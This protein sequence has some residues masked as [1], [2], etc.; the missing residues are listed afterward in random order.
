ME[1]YIVIYARNTATLALFQFSPSNQINTTFT[2]L[3]VY[4]NTQ[5]TVSMWQTTLL[6]SSAYSIAK[7]TIPASYTDDVTDQQTCN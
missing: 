6:T 3:E 2:T 1:E 4:T 7:G 5:S